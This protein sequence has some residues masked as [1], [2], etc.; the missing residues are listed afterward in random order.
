MEEKKNFKYFV[1]V[2]GVLFIICSLTALLLSFVNALT[3]DKIQ[4]N[5]QKKMTE[6]ISVLFEGEIKTEVI[7]IESDAPVSA[8]YEIKNNDSVVGYAVYL[9]QNGFKAEIELMVGVNLDGSCRGVRIISDSETPG[10]GAKI[11]EES[12][13][14]QYEGGYGNYVVKENITPIAGATISSKA[15]TDAV[16]SAI[17]TLK[18]G[19]IV[20]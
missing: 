14:N 7:D 13:Y 19:G 9:I 6:T 11:K 4:E 17:Q 5:A 18:N 10:L 1:R 16:N 8:V 3:K 15:V 2:A 20:A 12:F